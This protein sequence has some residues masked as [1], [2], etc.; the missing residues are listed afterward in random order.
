MFQFANFS[1]LVIDQTSAYTCDIEDTARWLPWW[2]VLLLGRDWLQICLNLRKSCIKLNRLETLGQNRKLGNWRLF[3]I[4]ASLR[5]RI[6]LLWNW[7]GCTS[8][9]S[10]STSVWWPD[11]RTLLS[12]QKSYIIICSW[13]YWQN[14]FFLEN[15]PPPKKK[16]QF[17]IFW[18]TV[19]SYWYIFVWPKM[20][21]QS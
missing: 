6:C 21:Y 16:L 9:Q 15:I 3:E 8:V 19:E 10:Y 1:V 4:R 14:I 20:Q 17:C 12:P 5:G 18:Y 7:P 11:C 2:Q 13:K